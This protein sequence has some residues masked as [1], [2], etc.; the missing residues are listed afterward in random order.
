MTQVEGSPDRFSVDIRGTDDVPSEHEV[1]VSD[2]DWQRFG[3]G[4]GTPE[5]LVEASF[6]FLL[7]REPK[8]SILRS[9]ALGV[10]QRY[11]PDYG[12]TFTPR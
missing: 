2:A 12:E 7:E 6:R 9:F 11:F 3:G 10:I 4:Y 8:D 1:V 5:E